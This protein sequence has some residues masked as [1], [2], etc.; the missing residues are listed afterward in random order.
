MEIRRAILDDV[1]AI[2]GLFDQARDAL[3]AAGIDQWQD[4]YPNEA[5]ARRDIKAG[6]GYVLAEGDQTLAYACLG[7][8]AEPTYNI[9]EQGSWISGGDYG[10]LHRVAVSDKAKGRGAAGLFFEE[11][12]RQA[13][14]RGVASIRGDTHRDN[15]PMRRVM[16]K[17]GLEYRGIIRVEDGTERLAYECVID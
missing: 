16:A 3:K 1:E 4:G 14:A 6:M 7:F 9:I 12:K 17:A 8:G 13:K 10:F 5:D 15:G 2:A 11:L